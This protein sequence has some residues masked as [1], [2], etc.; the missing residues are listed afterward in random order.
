MG[1]LYVTLAN[2][3]KGRRETNINDA[4]RSTIECLIPVEQ[5]GKLDTTQIPWANVRVGFTSEYK[6]NATVISAIRES[7]HLKDGAFDTK[8]K[9]IRIIADSAS[10]SDGKL[11]INFGTQS[12]VGLLNTNLRGLGDGGT[13]TRIICEALKTG[14][15]QDENKKQYVRLFVYCGDY[16]RDEMAE[17]V[18]SWNLGAN[19]KEV[20]LLNYQ[21]KFKVFKTML[22]KPSGILVGGTREPFPAVSFYSGEEGEY[23]IAELV[24]FVCLF[25]MDSGR[26]AY[27]GTGTC[28]DFFMNE[29]TQPKFLK[30]LP[31]LF[32]IVFL[33]ESI[34]AQLP[35]LYN[36]YANQGVGGRFAATRTIAKGSKN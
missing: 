12:K 24:Q 2:V 21:E 26:E 16:G 14:F 20:D 8:H 6:T 28:L 1:N 34:L 13:T 31:F 4:N 19:A 5:A 35:D 11:V 22:K 10:L 15:E 7:L 30:A 36:T 32:D 27:N 25:A 18:T 33:Y 3:E 17:M 23:S 9:G 29:E